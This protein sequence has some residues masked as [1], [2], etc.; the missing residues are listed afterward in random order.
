MLALLVDLE[1]L[2]ELVS[3]G[4]LFVFFCVSAGLI[5][6]RYCRDGD[7]SDP[8]R[9]QQVAIR[10]GTIVAC[11]F[12][13]PLSQ[14]AAKGLLGSWLTHVR[15]DAVASSH[16]S[17]RRQEVWGLSAGLE[18]A[19]KPDGLGARCRRERVIPGRRA[20]VG[21][22]LLRPALAGRRR[23]AVAAAARAR[24]AQQLH[25]AGQPAQPGRGHARQPAPHLCA[26][27]PALACAVGPRPS[28]GK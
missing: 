11:S 6:R 27:P 14:A 8:E 26:F 21:C 28:R 15:S 1:T 22:D 7:S 4:T 9:S 23:L 20:L 24:G 3:V 25:H 19:H 17:F 18:A 2:A 13:A 16:V 10:L 12:G 5:W